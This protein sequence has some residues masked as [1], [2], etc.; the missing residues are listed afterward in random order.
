MSLG[1]VRHL[2]G[3][4]AV[5]LLGA[6]SAATAA[7]PEQV[8]GGPN[9]S[10]NDASVSEGDEGL[11][12]VFFTVTLSGTSGAPVTVNFATADG[13]ATVADSD[14][15]PRSGV[16]TW[17]PG[18]LVAGVTISVVGDVTVEPDETFLVNLSN[19]SGG[20]VITD[21]QGVGTIV[22]DDV[23][24]E[25]L[26][27]SHGYVGRRSLASVG[28]AEKRD[29]Y[30][31][32][33]ERFASYE[34]VVDEASGDLQPLSLQL[35]DSD[36]STVLAESI[37]V[38]TGPAR[39]LRSPVVSSRPVTD[40][41]VRVSSGGCQTDC[42]PDDTYRIRAY[43]TTFRIPRFN[44]SGSQVTLVVLH[45]PTDEAI[46]GTALFWDPSGSPLATSLFL[47]NPKET[48]VVFGSG[49]PGL[50][51]SITVTHSG[52]Y[53]SLAGKAVSLEPATGFSF[54]TPMLPRDR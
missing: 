9:A 51:G 18:Q 36:G 37:P 4:T 44:N 7:A 15:L 53:G 17:A 31:I 43:E 45:N 29:I 50:S 2:A 3:G 33:Q 34:V 6:T 20:G 13:T 14:Y 35:I 21:P 23:G 27:L 5:F 28:G 42:G 54:D 12:D 22:N 19:L 8:L 32:A 39:S 52:P 47:L 38:G 30:R 49:V 11:V 41:T 10:I 48:T 46:G 26:E 25:S 24:L 1:L 16:L 40:Q